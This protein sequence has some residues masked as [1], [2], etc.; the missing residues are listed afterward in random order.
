[1]P[2]KGKEP[3]GK[4][5]VGVMPDRGPT[6]E[7]IDYLWE[8][9]PVTY[10]GMGMTP[11][12]W[13]DL[14]AWQGVTGAMLDPWEAGAVMDLSIAYV[15]QHDRSKSATC[16]PPWVDPDYVDHVSLGSKILSQFRAFQKRRTEKRGG[17]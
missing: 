17:A 3:R 10:G 15:D 2:E 13:R 14:Q 7:L 1:M 6:P 5:Y 11:L 12:T 8:I 16:P 4:R 9:G